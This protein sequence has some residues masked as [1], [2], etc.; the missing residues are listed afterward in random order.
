MFLLPV[1]VINLSYLLVWLFLAFIYFKLLQLVKIE[2]LFP[3]GKI[4]EIRVTYFLLTITLS[5]LTTE[6]LYKLF[7]IFNFI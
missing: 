7:S 4:G 3:Q 2:R 6:A 5:F 1:I